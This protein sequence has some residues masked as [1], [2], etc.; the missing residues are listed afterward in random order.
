[1]RLA[2]LFVSFV[3][4]SGCAFDLRFDGERRLLRDPETGRCMMVPEHY[5]AAGWEPC[6]DGES[7]TGD[8]DCGDGSHCSTRDGECLPH[9]GCG[10]GMDCPAVCTGVCVPDEATC[11]HDGQCG[12]GFHCS[13][14]DGD[15]LPP[16]GCDDGEV[17]PA[18]CGGVCVPDGIPP[19]P[20]CYAIESEATCIAR[21]D[22]EPVYVGS[23]CH[24]DAGGCG[25]DSHTFAECR[26]AQACDDATS[27][28]LHELH[29]VWTS[30]EGAP[31]RVYTFHSPGA[32][33]SGSFQVDDLVAPCPAG[34]QCVWSGIIT[35][36]GTF[37]RDA[38]GA[39]RLTYVEPMQTWP[40]LRFA[41]SVALEGCGD[42]RR[43]VEVDTGRAF[44]RVPPPSGNQ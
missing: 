27:P 19:P 33:S 1:M 30:R 21:A 2:W 24:C 16:P 39:V 4:L 6:D 12:A 26:P 32:A 38:S 34:A 9:P 31:A 7:C 25:C 22:C 11:T 37:A 13:T 15:C 28:P 3:T 18:V 23:D 36:K 29:G 43:L 42:E 17:C 44:R 10:D 20:T 35:N 5:Q 8:A 40:G 14:R 41:S